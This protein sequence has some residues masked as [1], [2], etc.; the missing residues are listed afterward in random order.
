[1]EDINIPSVVE[2]SITTHGPSIDLFE[3]MAARCTTT[4]LISTT[5][6]WG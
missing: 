5:S 6:C 1:M 3:P 4:T 2:L